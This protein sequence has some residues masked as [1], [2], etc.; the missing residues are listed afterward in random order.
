MSSEK[1]YYIWRSERQGPVEKE[2]ILTK[3]TMGELQNH[4]YVWTKGLETWRKIG[5]LDIL[6]EELLKASSREEI[7]IEPVSE[8]VFLKDLKSEGRNIYI[9]IGAD[10]GIKSNDYGPFNFSQLIKLYQE[11]RINNKSFVFCKTADQWIR[12]G[13]FE[14][15]SEVL[16]GTPPLDERRS[17]TRRPFIARL[18]LNN[19][20]KFFEG[21]CRD[22]SIGGMQV[23]V[24]HFS[25]TPGDE[26]SINV[27][28]ENKDYHFVA[29]GVVVRLLEGNSGFS[30]R[31]RELSPEAKKAIEN[32][33]LDYDL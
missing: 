31:F 3:I 22:I 20:K 15:F 4:D 11:N 14:D 12:L 8:K 29:D 18:F 21:I 2:E 17:E 19:D 1:W 7:K 16:G 23:L 9:R 24:D 10:R 27:H 28:P 6:K 25:G 30:F 33:L 5:E 13:D 26:I 32:Y